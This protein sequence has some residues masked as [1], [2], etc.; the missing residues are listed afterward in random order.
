VNFCR[1][2]STTRRVVHARCPHRERA[3][4]DRDTSFA[5]VAVA[6]DQRQVVAVPLLRVPVQVRLDLDLQRLGQHPPRA[7]ERQLVQRRPHLALRFVRLLDYPQHRRAFPRA[8]KRGPVG[9][10]QL[11]RVRATF[12]SRRST[13]SGHISRRTVA[14][15]CCGEMSILF[16]TFL[17][18]AAPRAMGPPEYDQNGSSH[19]NGPCLRSRADARP[20]VPARS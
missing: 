13:T 2:P 1:S 17:G 7:L 8:G 3:R 11:G 20:A 5:R 4:P 15:V 12:S 10:F 19:A 16:H 14:S 9:W 18:R 6:H